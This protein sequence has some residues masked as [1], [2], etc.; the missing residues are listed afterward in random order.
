MRLHALLCNQ[1]GV[2]VLNGVV[3]EVVDASR[4]AATGRVLGKRHT[5]P[6]R[7]KLRPRIAG[8]ISIHALF[9]IRGI[10]NGRGQALQRRPLITPHGPLRSRRK[11]T[12]AELTRE[13]L[14]CQRAA[15]AIPSPNLHC[16]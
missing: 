11:A 3:V 4:P 16:L 7:A 14:P 2:A 15:Q 9:T 10:V 12:E 8:P 6:R 1:I 5:H 13:L